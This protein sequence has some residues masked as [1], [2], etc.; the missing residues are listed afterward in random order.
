LKTN[1]RQLIYP[2]TATHSSAQQ[3]NPQLPQRYSNGERHLLT[4]KTRSPPV[5]GIFDAK[6]DLYWLKPNNPETWK[7][8]TTLI[9]R[10]TTENDNAIFTTRP[11]RGP[12]ALFER[13]GK[14]F[15]D[16]TNFF[17]VRPAGP[18]WSR[19]KRG[20]GGEQELKVS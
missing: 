15:L 5:R 10:E 9:N 7:R 3:Q 19:S 6:N 20:T 17:L 16:K 18:W 1:N 14:A 2:I 11:L 4:A 13:H 8:L 12:Q